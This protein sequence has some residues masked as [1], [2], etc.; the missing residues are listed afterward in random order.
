[1]VREVTRELAAEPSPPTLRYALIPSRRVQA[2]L[3][4]LAARPIPLIE[5]HF[6]L[7]GE[8]F[9]IA[10]GHLGV[11]SLHLEWWG[12]GPAEWK[13]VT[14]W[15]RQLMDELKQRI[16]SHGNQRSPWAETRRVLVV[17]GPV[18]RGRAEKAL[19]QLHDLPQELVGRITE[20]L[21]AGH[22]EIEG[23]E[24]ELKTLASRLQGQGV[25]TEL[26]AARIEG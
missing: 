24:S 2:A 23:W 4:E 18:E 14:T 7:D 20:A 12:D 8:T 5:G 19:R 16:A 15:A 26:R 22:P 13:S 3:D 17:C 6:G 21:L 10:M 9:G 25:R 1:M 11:T